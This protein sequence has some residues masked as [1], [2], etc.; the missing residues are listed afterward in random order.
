MKIFNSRTARWAL[1]FL[2]LIGASGLSQAQVLYGTLTG[3]VTDPSGALVPGAKVEAQ[4]VATGLVRNVETDD[5]GAYLFNN[6]PLGSYKVTVRATSFSP[7]IQTDVQVNPNEVRRLDMGL[8]LAATTEAV[9]VSAQALVLQTDKG[10]VHAEIT[11]KEVIEL[12]YNGGQGRNFQSLI[13]LLPG[14]VGPGNANREA[15]SDAG[16]PARAQTLFMNGQS[17]TGNSTK[18][19][20]AT[21]SYPW[22]PVNI[23][24]VPPSDAIEVINVVTNAFDAEQGAAG[25]AAVNVSIKSGTNRLHGTAYEYH[26]DNAMLAQ[27]FFNHSNTNAPAKNVFNQYGFSLGGPVIIPKLYNG[28]NKL[29]W[30]VDWQGTKRNQY[31][32]ALNL[33][34][35]QAAWR[36]GDLSSV[37][38]NCPATCIYDP[39]TGN[40]DGTNRQPFPNNIIP[41]ARLATSDSFAP[42]LLAGLLPAVSRPT[43]ANGTP[44]Y[45]SNTD[46]YGA[47]YFHRN[48]WD[49]KLNY[50][51][52]DKATIWG[53]YSILP[54]Q[55]LAPLQLGPIAG[56]DAFNGGNP[57]LAGGRVQ[58]TGV[59]FTYAFTN[60]LFLDGNFG[61]TRQ[62]IGANGD[63]YNGAYGLNTLKIPGTNG[64]GELYAGVPGFQVSGIAN[65]G[66]TNTGS[67]FLFRDNQYT[68]AYNLTKVIGAHNLRFGFNYDHYALNH[69]QPQGGTFGTARGTF[70][71]DGGLTGLCQAIAANGTC[72]TSS[73]L[74]QVTGFNS[75]AEFLLG[76]P[77]RMGK[78]TQYQNPNSLRFSDYSF[79][80]RD[81]WQVNQRLTV[82]IGL[83]W[84]YYPIFGHDNYGASRYDLATNT[85][86]IGCLG[87]TP[88]DTGASANK[89][90][91]APRFGFAYRLG[92][93]TV[94]RGGYGITVDPDN[95]RNQRNNYPSVVNQDY[96]PNQFHV[97]DNAGV[98]ISTLATGIPAAIF[99]DISKGVI[100][101]A[102]PPIAT[103]PT[104][105]GAVGSP[106]TFLPT[107]G[108]GTFVKNLDRGY[109][110]SWNLFIQHEITPSTV[111]EL[112]YVGS[113][114]V[115][116]MMQ[117]NVNGSLPGTGNAGRYLYPYNIADM[118][119][120][121]PFGGTKYESLQA[122]FKK[123]F[124]ISQVNVAY[125]WSKAM[126]NINGDNG[127]GTLFRTWP[128]ST[129]LAW[130]DAGFDRTHNLQISDILHLPFGHGHKFMNHGISSVIFGGW[131]VSST[132]ARTSGSPFTVASSVGV[133]A[134]GQSQT[135][136]QINP[137]VTI[138][139]GHDTLHPYFDG[140]AFAN[141]LPSTLGTSGRNLLRG[142]G[143]FNLDARI[144][145]TFDLMK[146][147]KLKLQLI[148][149]AF[150]V[151]NHPN[152]SN[153]NASFNAP[154]LTNG[155]VTN[156]NNYSVIS[157]TLANGNG[158]QLQVA[159]R[160]TF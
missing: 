150:S 37:P 59:G 135:A 88:C 10:D 55:I 92:S 155:V 93:K 151:T 108:T 89:K 72:A 47:T 95:M 120:Y 18:L 153:P 14:A 154:T 13:Y 69:F 8:R 32:Q 71:F 26:Q 157:S 159:A 67:P 133:N 23:A 123:R 45:S 132:L 28:K 3:N 60:T 65:I 134:G 131:E 102:C 1:A 12:P 107:T 100:T 114:G 21:I 122:Q 82:S 42:L 97:I 70:G 54:M 139:G 48:N 68:T 16:N 7:M 110:Q 101:S 142:P 19:D 81:Q 24:Y 126:N 90:N 15:N 77:S 63:E 124:G 130:A 160:L 119:A 99:P 61:Y 31:A 117:A 83:R 109:I 144:A 36:K 74:N 38:A 35:P 127:D 105:A 140:T 27:P 137:N 129:A 43:Q 85:I 9:E 115:R 91:F 11:S 116:L 79:Y 49:I 148:G 66:N 75:W 58:S 39:K 22:L 6:L 147:G 50:N 121:Y 33:T 51:P 4:N 76:V 128:V 118:N 40:P 17:S 2:F 143:F 20:G 25:G 56:G 34:L 5:R 94:V 64:V 53:R 84:E 62:N 41:A 73:Q 29:F 86:L 149:D 112:G 145:R 44:N 152:F 104:C 111:V 46:I 138:L 78:I 146:E 52:T 98:A 125:T 136:N 30:F 158:R 87:G 141:P 57:G 156:Y 113:R 106:T 96:N 103:N 80:A